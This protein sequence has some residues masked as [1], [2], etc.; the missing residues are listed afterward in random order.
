[1]IFGGQGKAKVLVSKVTQKRTNRR[2][3]N[4]KNCLCAIVLSE[5]VWKGIFNCE[6]SV[7]IRKKQKK[8]F[9]KL[10]TSGHQKKLL[11]RGEDEAGMFLNHRSKKYIKKLVI[12]LIG[13]C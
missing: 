5:M 8:F 3:F 11:Q 1:M 7:D 6:M 2:G 9:L 13:L 4:S 10:K 12:L